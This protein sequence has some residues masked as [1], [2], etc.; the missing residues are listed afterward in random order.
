[1]LILQRIEFRLYGSLYYHNPEISTL[2]RLPLG[3]SL[4]RRERNTAYFGRIISGNGTCTINAT[5]PYPLYAPPSNHLSADPA[6]IT[7]SEP[8]TLVRC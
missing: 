8:P 4:R 2:K 5:I 6:Y 1:M 3:S 7:H